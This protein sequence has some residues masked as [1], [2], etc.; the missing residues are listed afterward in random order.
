[1]VPNG[2]HPW[3]IMSFIL[4]FMCMNLL[5]QGRLIPGASFTDID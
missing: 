3:V 2:L 5:V 1:M 4:I